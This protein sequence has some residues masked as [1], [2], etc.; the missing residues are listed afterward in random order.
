MCGI[1]ALLGNLKINNKIETSFNK[2]K[3]RGPEYSKLKQVTDNIIFGFHRLAINGLDTGSHQPLAINNIELICNGEIYNYK[4][5]YELMNITSETHSD[6]EVII[7]LYKRYGIDQTIEMLDGVFAFILYD[8]DTS[9]IYVARD[10]YGVRPLFY[11]VRPL[12]YGYS[13]NECN[14]GFASELKMIHHLFEKCYVF[15]PGIYSYYKDECY[16]YSIDYFKGYV[17]NYSLKDR[18][19]ILSLI[20]NTL[21]EA[22]RKRIDTS[23]RPIACLLSGGLDSSLITSLV[24]KYYPSLQTYSI[25]LEGSEDLKY[26]KQVSEYLNTTHNE[27]IVSE[28]DFLNVIPEVIK[29]IESYDTTSIRASVGNYLVAKYIKEHSDAKVI[30]NGD[31]SD[32]ITGGYLYFHKAPD[33]IEFDKECKRLLSN[34]HLFDVL[35][36]DRCIAAHGLE[37]RTPFLDKSFVTTYL[38]IPSHIRNHNN[39]KVMEKNLLRNA[40]IGYLPNKVLFRKKEAFSDGVSKQTRSWFQIIQEYIETLNI[41][42]GINYEFNCP[43]TKEQYYY[44]YIFEKHYS[45]RSHIIPYFWMPKYVNATDASART[46]D[47][48]KNVK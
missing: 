11:G 34:I 17:I 2:G 38:S 46:L 45:N 26:A 29:M 8:K 30:F 23:D 6:C 43:Q 36:S 42:N 33:S 21:I 13:N 22:V 5:L 3:E 19:N 10:L 41:D 24:S 32:E 25:G 27:I 14:Y 28:E 35:R 37:A 12:F 4:E 18:H 1:F 20:R 7:H 31:G 9:E 39:N 40:F 48:Y 47:I 15:K 16:Q 44:R